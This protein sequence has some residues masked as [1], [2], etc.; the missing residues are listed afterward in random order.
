MAHLKSIL[1]GLLG[2]R[3]R[4][5]VEAIPKQVVFRNLLDANS[6]LNSLGIRCWL[7]DGTLL[8]FFREKDLIE[9]DRDV[10]L[11]VRIE[12]Y[13][14]GIIPEFGKQGFEL[15]YVL[16]EKRQGLELSFIRA[17]A[18]VDLFFFYREGDRMWHG[19]WQGIDKGRKR[20]LIKYYYDAFDLREAEFLGEKFF[21]PA[22]TLK[23]IETKY[24]RDWRTPIRE[25]DWA[26]GP[27]NAVGT[28]VVLGRNKKK[29][30]R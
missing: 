10:D 25:W 13:T 21:V 14:D 28:D 26:F 24:G 3:K 7:T 23:Y 11:G 12:D 16:G 9:H 22:D 30:V 4:R 19:A 5:Q 8:G 15:K 18:K 6:I 2:I 17:G 20:N 1:L 27:A 29:I